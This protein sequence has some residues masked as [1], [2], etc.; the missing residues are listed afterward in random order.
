MAAPIETFQEQILTLAQ[1]RDYHGITRQSE[2]VDNPDCAEVIADM[3]ELVAAEPSIADFYLEALN[4]YK[5]GRPDSVADEL[6]VI[7]ERY[8]IME[9]EDLLTPAQA[10]KVEEQLETGEI[11]EAEARAFFKT[12]K[13]ALPEVVKVPTQPR[14]K[15][16]KPRQARTIDLTITEHGGISVNGSLLRELTP[17]QR[18]IILSGLAKGDGFRHKE[19]ASSDEFRQS[20]GQNLTDEETRE[21]YN[22]EFK[23]L[24]AVLTDKG[25]GRLVDPNQKPHAR[26]HEIVATTIVDKRPE[27]Q[28]KPAVLKGRKPSA[29]IGTF[30]EQQDDASG[31]GQVSTAEQEIVFTPHQLNDTRESILRSMQ[32]EGSISRGKAVEMAV[33]MFGIDA[34]T[35]RRLVTEVYRVERASDNPAFTQKKDGKKKFVVVDKAEEART[36]QANPLNGYFEGSLEE[37]RAH[38]GEARG[39]TPDSIKYERGSVRLDGVEKA[40]LAFYAQTGTRKAVAEKQIIGELDR[41]GYEISNNELRKAARVINRL[42]GKEFMTLMPPSTGRSAAKGP[43]IQLAGSFMPVPR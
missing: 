11:V 27:M 5:K 34:R 28:P 30:Y 1:Y 37:F 21:V 17:A 25:L 6:A 35:A 3:A 42:V 12:F 32:S 13:G 36:E 29:R 40:V 14:K 24:K 33:D 31:E 10:R 26:K 38:Y 23:A 19:I 2:I 43:R 18:V 16:S 20:L 4:K 15:P 9:D 41:Q 8:A 22:D 7:K 39:V